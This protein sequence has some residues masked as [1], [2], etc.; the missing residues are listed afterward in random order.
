MSALTGAAKN[1]RDRSVLMDTARARTADRDHAAPG[2]VEALLRSVYALTPANRRRKLDE[3]GEDTAWQ[4]K[5]GPARWLREQR[6]GPALSEFIAA[7]EALRDG[8][9]RALET[10]VNLKAFTSVVLN[11]EPPTVTRYGGHGIG[12]QYRPDVAR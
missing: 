7:T 1:T 11:S 6:P 10:P 2:D 4:P 5:E 8:L 12:H 9:R 3:E